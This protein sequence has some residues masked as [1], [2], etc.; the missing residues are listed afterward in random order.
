MEKNSSQAGA[1]RGRRG[2]PSHPLDQLQSASK[3]LTSIADSITKL[4]GTPDGIELLK[5]WTAAKDE[6][7]KKGKLSAK[8]KQ[9]MKLL[10]E[11]PDLEDVV[12]DQLK[13]QIKHKS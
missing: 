7:S 9:I 3:K 8:Q 6:S 13:V 1:N 10:T 11:N 4:S 2:A 12:L 5:S